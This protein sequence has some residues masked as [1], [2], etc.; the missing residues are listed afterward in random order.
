MLLRKFASFNTTVCYIRGV[1]NYYRRKSA[2]REY[3]DRILS[4][5]LPANLPENQIRHRDQF[6][7]RPSPYLAIYLRRRRDQGSRATVHHRVACRV[8]LAGLAASASRLVGQTTIVAYTAF[9]FFC[10]RGAPGCSELA[11][12]L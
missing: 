11:Q 1:S 5:E 2:N 7:N 9:V 4:V 12:N 10:A 3:A 8:S 6:E